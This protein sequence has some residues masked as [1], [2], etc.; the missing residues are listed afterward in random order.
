M[1]FQ[2][3]VFVAACVALDPGTAVTRCEKVQTEDFATQIGCAAKAYD[4]IKAD[5]SKTAVC[6]EQA[7]PR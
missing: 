6:V 7:A 5:R 3:S 4:I 2:L 1:A